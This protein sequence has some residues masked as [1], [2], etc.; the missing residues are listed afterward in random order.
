MALARAF[1]IPLLLPLALAGCASLAPRRHANPWVD[2]P[3]AVAFE[4]TSWGR[5]V[6]GWRIERSG[7]G[8]RRTLREV[9]GGG[10]HNYD[11]V[12]RR[13]SAGPEGFERIRMLMAEA[14]R[15]IDRGASCRGGVTDAGEGKLVWELD[16]RLDRWM[17]DYGCATRRRVRI[18]QLLTEAS[19]LAATWAEGSTT[20]EEVEQV[21]LSEAP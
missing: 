17:L 1:L 11:I 21:R 20:A 3:D 5:L 7:V 2:R 13:F 15:I 10:F 8:V 16:G 19:G 4:S 14:R 12:M 6:F 9:Q 18:S